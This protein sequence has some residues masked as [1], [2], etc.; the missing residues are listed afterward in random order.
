MELIREALA[1]APPTPGVV[2]ARATIEESL[3]RRG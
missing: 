2:R 1:L 3:R